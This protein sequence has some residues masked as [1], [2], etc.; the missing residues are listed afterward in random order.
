MK[1]VHRAIRVLP[2]SVG[3]ILCTIALFLLVARVQRTVDAG[4]EVRV[5]RYQVVR[6][7]I[8]GLVAGVYVQPGEWVSRGQVLVQLEDFQSRRDLMT[9]QQSLSDAQGRLEKS[10]VER[11]LLEATVQ[12]LEIRKQDA[13]LRENSIAT[14]LS[15]SKVKEA[16]IQLMGA[17]ERLAKARELSKLGLLSQQD[18]NQA[19]QEEQLQ[20]QR[21]AQSRL[22]EQLATIHRPALDNDLALLKSEQNRLRSSLDAEIRSLEDQVAQWTAQRREIEGMMGLRTLRA[23]MDGVVSAPPTRDLL[24]RSVKAG[25]DLFSVIDVTSIS[26]LAHVPEEA[27]VRVRAGQ[28]A[29]VEIAGLPKQRFDLFPGTVRAV[30]QEPEPK[31]G[32]GPIFYPVRLQLQTPWIVLAEGGK[33]YLRSGMQGAARIAYKRNVPLFEALV[34]LLVGRSEIRPSHLR[35]HEGNAP[36]RG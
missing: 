1:L 26:F 5:E 23:E 15:A 2:A 28:T 31:T 18:L 34:D 29:Y 20:E 6:P 10:R 25:E 11:Q 22:D 36:S 17:K 8:A 12:P 30:E 3:L 14:A 9:V 24:G 33:F 13:A 32:S 7:Q 27:I 35:E 21:L 19:N 4:G 16:E